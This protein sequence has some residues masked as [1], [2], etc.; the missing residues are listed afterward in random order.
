MNR[1]TVQTLNA[2][3][4]DFYHNQAEEFAATREK[5][6]RGWTRLIELLDQEFRDIE[7][8]SVLDVGC[9]NGRFGRFLLD[10][11]RKSITYVGVDISH[12]ALSHARAR[13]SDTDRFVLLQ[14]DLVAS[15]AGRMLPRGAR[16]PFSL[17]VAWGLFHHVPGYHTR[18]ALASELSRRLDSHGILAI[19]L[20]QFGRFERFRKKI[21]AW[22]AFQKTTGI[23]VD[24]GELEPGDYILPWED[25][26]TAFRY[27]HFIDPDEARRLLSSLPLEQLATFSADG[28]TNDL[29]QYYVM[30]KRPV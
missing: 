12:K 20:W 13:L 16:R 10:H 7:A 9:G 28:A 21:I 24:P 6:W 27:C 26:P 19:S 14:H 5:P 8:P 25:S 2:I 22:E 18:Q 29:N 11:Y 1:R 4:R 3:N 17:I 15:P 30:R 23:Q